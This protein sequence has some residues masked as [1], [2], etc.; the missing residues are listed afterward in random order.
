MHVNALI[1]LCSVAWFYCAVSLTSEHVNSKSLTACV[2]QLWID[3]V[4]RWYCIKYLWTPVRAPVG[5]VCK[6]KH[7]HVGLH[8]FRRRPASWE[9]PDHVSSSTVNNRRMS[10]GYINKS[11]LYT[12]LK[13][14][15]YITDKAE[16]LNPQKIHFWKLIR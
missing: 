10:L 6:Q 2:W 13:R 11:R 15:R 5:Y 1:D 4:F 12:R 16:A 7:P 8:I 14:L 9:E 3:H